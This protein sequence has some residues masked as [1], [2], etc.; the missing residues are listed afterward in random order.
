MTGRGVP[1][2]DVTGGGRISCRMIDWLGARRPL[3]LILLAT[4]LV[5]LA[6]LGLQ[7][8]FGL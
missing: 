1:H 7:R 3:D 2:G 4:A 5:A 8:W 6:T